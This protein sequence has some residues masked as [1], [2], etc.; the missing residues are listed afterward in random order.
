MKTYQLKG[1]LQ[2]KKWVSPAFVTVDEDGIIASIESKPNGLAIH[3]QLDCFAIPGFQNSHS[4]AFQYA[5]AG[6]AELHPTA[7]KK[8]DFWSWRESMYALALKVQPEHIEAI[9]AMLYKEMLRHGYTHVAEFHYI[10]HQT[11]GSKYDNLAEMG[12]RMI[13]AAKNIVFSVQGTRLG[14]SLWSTF[15]FAFSTETESNKKKYSF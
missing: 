9:A 5:M 14:C 4:H 2:N 8:N 11:D 10:H 13:N 6:L 1:L 12:Q 3:H 7:M 15:A